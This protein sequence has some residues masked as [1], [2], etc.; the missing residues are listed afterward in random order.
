MEGCTVGLTIRPTPIR[1]NSLICTLHYSLNINCP[2]LLTAKEN[3]EI[4]KSIS[5]H[6][7]VTRITKI[8]QNRGGVSFQ[9]GQIAR[10][11][12]EMI[13]EIMLQKLPYFPQV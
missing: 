1:D 11:M 8:P 4:I 6:F 7:A 3:E 5:L 2:K 10:K 9:G 13:L 12:S